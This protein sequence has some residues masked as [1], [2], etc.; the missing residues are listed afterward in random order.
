MFGMVVVFGLFHGL[1]FLPVLLSLIGP[2]GPPDEDSEMSIESPVVVSK[3]D[4]SN[5]SN[6]PINAVSP[7][8]EKR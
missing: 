7:D 5:R 4:V 6:S 1:I 3:E 2:A 8:V